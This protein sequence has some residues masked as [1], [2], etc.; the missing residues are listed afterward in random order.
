MIR[1]ATV[2]DALCVAKLAIQMW[3]DNTVEGL[4]EDLTKIIDSP[5]S[6]VFLLYDG[7]IAIGF[8]QCQLRHDYVEGTDSSP[9]GY[10]EGIFVEEAYRNK[11]YAKELLKQCEAWAKDMGC[12]EFASDCELENTGSLAFHLKMGFEEANRVIC[13]TKKL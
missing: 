2:N 10:L 9:V 8:A 4:A 12:T 11:G 7:E 6:A 3:E 5:E 13:F 1:K